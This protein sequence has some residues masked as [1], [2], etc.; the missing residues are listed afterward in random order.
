MFE[1]RVDPGKK[2]RLEVK[3][4][5]FKVFGEEV[6]VDAGGRK[7]V[8]VRLEPKE[9]SPGGRPTRNPV[10]MEPPKT[11]LEKDLPKTV[12]V[13]LGGGVKMEFVLIPKGKFTMGSPKDEK[14]RNP[15]VKAPV[16][17]AEEQHDVEITKPF[18]LAKYPVTQE[19]YV[20][21]TGKENP[22]FYSAEG[23]GKDKVPA[24]TRQFPVE[25]V[26]WEDAKACCEKMIKSDKQSRKFR[27]PSEAEWE[28]A[29][30]AGTETPF[31]FGAVL[32]GKQENCNGNFPYGT[33][34]KGPYLNRTSEVGHYPANKWD[35]H[36]MHG[37]V[38]QWC[39]DYYGPYEGLGTKDP[40]RSDKYS[41]KNRVMRGGSKHCTSQDCRAACRGWRAPDVREN[42]A[43][44]RVCFRPE[45][46]EP[47]IGFEKPT[48]PVRVVADDNGF[49]PLFNGK[50]LTGWK[51]HNGKLE[52]WGADKG[53]LYVEGGGGGWLMTEQEYGDFELRLE[54]KIPRMGNSGVA[55]RA[56][57]IGDPAC[58]GMEVQILDDANYQNLRPAQLCGSI[59]DVVAPLKDATK[60]F[61]EWNTYKIVAKG[62]QITI[63]LNG[64]KIVDAN[65]DDYIKEHG[66]KHPGLSREKGHLGLQS[67][68][69][70]FEFRNIEIKELPPAKFDSQ[71]FVPLFNGKDLT[72]WKTHPQD[73]ATWE[74]KDGILVSSGPVGHLYSEKDNYTNFHFRVEAMINDGGNSGQMFRTVFSPGF[75]KGY[76]AQI[77]STHGDP[78]RT[79][80]LYPA[81]PLA[82]GA[83]D[84]IVVKEQLHKPDEWFI[85]EVIA[86]GNH[87]IIKVNGKT[88]VD[89][90]DPNNTYT[91]GHLALQQHNLGTVVQFRKIEIKELTPVKEPTKEPVVLAVLSHQIN[92]KTA[93]E[94]RLYSNGHINSPDNADTWELRGNTLIFRWRN[95]NAPGGVWIDICTI[96]KDGK[97]FSGMNNNKPPAQISGE[98]RSDGELGKLLQKRTE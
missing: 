66:V 19:Q 61:G 54:C 33:N 62:K 86:D 10:E 75:P 28:Y 63:E 74:V 96:S 17:D 48:P 68:D 22:S 30:R 49:V 91:K 18:Y 12:T 36:D 60:P 37:N 27:L 67:H 92:G 25:R 59:Y 72:G 70:R 98:N 2:H 55:L 5:G 90:V 4:D 83:R 95:K 47:K 20:A 89:F 73:K 35:L 24:N 6:E 3:K 11:V 64:V 34:E 85:Q 38:W 50:D 97:K 58:Q 46:D 29:C 44:F 43:G 56:P 13:D 21:I 81:F 51:V 26:D 52:V 7:S 8:V 88:T 41:V 84:K 9:N 45:L 42:D 79:G 40:L 69:G 71:G 32:N 57:L 93:G 14:G 31:H 16:Y 23:G 1:V 53:I 80:S 39:E 87:I 77:N 94:N 82:L 15:W 78:I 76:E 65:L